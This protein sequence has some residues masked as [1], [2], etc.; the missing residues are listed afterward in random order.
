MKPAFADQSDI[1][2]DAALS[3]LR[4]VRPAWGQANAVGGRGLARDLLLLALILNARRPAALTEHLRRAAAATLRSRLRSAAAVR[5]CASHARAFLTYGAVAG[6]AFMAAA[7]EIR[8]EGLALIEKAEALVS[9]I[10]VGGALEARVVDLS[11]ARG[12]RPPRAQLKVLSAVIGALDRA[13]AGDSLAATEVA[14]IRAY[15][16]QRAA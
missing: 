11:G 10:D 13:R 6:R 12:G 14:L 2:A 16:Q 15:L 7:E 9:S 3:A 1:E 5:K 8:G 4:E